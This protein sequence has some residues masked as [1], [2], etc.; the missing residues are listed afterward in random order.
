MDLGLA[1]VEWADGD[2][3]GLRKSVPE[4]VSWAMFLL[5]V[6]WKAK[7]PRREQP[8]PPGRLHQ[9]RDR[10]RTRGEHGD[11]KIISPTR[12]R[13]PG[14]RYVRRTLGPRRTSAGGLFHD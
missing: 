3:G 14:A 6:V 11:R 4:M 5:A 7:R 13:T 9:P 2:G 1:D 12:I 10:R 8:V